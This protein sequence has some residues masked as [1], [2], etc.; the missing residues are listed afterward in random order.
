VS[1]G[2]VG[3][4]SLGHQ[5]IAV[6]SAHRPSLSSFIHSYFLSTV[7]G[8]PGPSAGIPRIP[9]NVNDCSSFFKERRVGTLSADAQRRHTL[10]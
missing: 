9:D 6:P 10:D 8:V 1:V 3:S 7:A 4:L 5:P 2:S